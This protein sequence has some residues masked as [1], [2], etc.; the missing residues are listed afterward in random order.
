MN[1]RVTSVKVLEDY[2]LELK[3]GNGEI[4]HFSMQPYLDY[5]VYRPLKDYTLFNK[6]RATMGFI[7]WNQDIDMS[8]DTLYLESKIIA[9]T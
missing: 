9:Q 7:S 4:G 1:P 3:F 5:P 6:A 2:I 8:P